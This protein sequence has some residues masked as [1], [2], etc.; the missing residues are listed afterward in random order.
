MPTLQTR[1]AGWLPE[2]SAVTRAGWQCPECR[3]V[4]SPDV[5]SCEC[6]TGRRSLAERIGHAPV[7]FGG[8]CTCLPNGLGT[9]RCPV[10]QGVLPTVVIC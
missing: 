10:H 6:A 5:R 9:A 2:P 7:T 4:Y 1:E 3:T 8:T